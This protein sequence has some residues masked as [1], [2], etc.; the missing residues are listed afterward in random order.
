[1]CNNLICYFVLFHT[2]TVIVSCSISTNVDHNISDI[3]KS[4]D[5]HDADETKIVEIVKS[6]YEV[7][8]IILKCL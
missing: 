3:K 4:N 8:K 6:M 2:H 7:I 1:M 5:N